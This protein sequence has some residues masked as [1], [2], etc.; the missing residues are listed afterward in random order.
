MYKLPFTGLPTRIRQ[1][2]DNHHGALDRLRAHLATPH[3]AVECFA[4]LFKRKIGSGEYGFA[5]IEAI[6]HVNHLYL[7][8]EATRTEAEGGVWL[9][10]CT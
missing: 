1:L 10:H 2:I 5:L 7:A 9:Y 3:R 6:A 4:S 8:G